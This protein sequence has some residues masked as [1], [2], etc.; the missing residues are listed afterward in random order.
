[1]SVP[2][3][4]QRPRGSAERLSRR[5]RSEPHKGWWRDFA[6]DPAGSGFWHETDRRSGGM[7]AI[8]LGMPK[9]IGLG[10]FAAARAPVGPFMTARGRIAA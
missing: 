3:V 5:R 4:C 9:P 6:K 1:M 7:E 2:P 8:D 10:S